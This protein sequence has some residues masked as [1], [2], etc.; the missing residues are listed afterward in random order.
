MLLAG[1]MSVTALTACTSGSGETTGTESTGTENEGGEA[2]TTGEG[3]ELTGTLNVGVIGPMT[4]AAAIYGTAVKNGAKNINESSAW[5]DDSELKWF[6]VDSDG[7]G[8]QMNADHDIINSE[9]TE[10]SQ[11]ITA[12]SAYGFT[13]DNCDE[14]FTSLGMAAFQASYQA[15]TAVNNLL[16]TT[17]K[18]P[19]ERTAALSQLYDAVGRIIMTNQSI[20]DK[21][22]L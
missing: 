19:Q 3:G 15:L 5:S 4:G 17:F 6:E 1:V 10:F 20:K 22:S 18:T 2:A 16:E 7:L 11:V 9:L 8:M 21:E 13:F 12:T 14:T